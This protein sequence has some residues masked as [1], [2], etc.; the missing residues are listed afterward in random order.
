MSILS[1][2][3]PSVVRSFQRANTLPSSLDV[4]DWPMI[5]FCVFIHF[6]TGNLLKAF[7]KGLCHLFYISKHPSDGYTWLHLQL[8]LSERGSSFPVFCLSLSQPA[9]LSERL[10]DI[11]LAVTRLSEACS[12]WLPSASRGISADIVQALR[13][14]PASF[15]EPLF[16][17]SACSG[18]ELTCGVKTNHITVL[19][20]T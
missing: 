15:T 3:L 11:L 6:F 12:G 2:I 7:W 14:F 18:A 10:W 19:L 5:W 8:D 17:P 9:R 13:S 1:L 4:A 16:P 20:L